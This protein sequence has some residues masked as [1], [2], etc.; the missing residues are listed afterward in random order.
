[1][2]EALMPGNAGDAA[3][4]HA[5]AVLAIAAAAVALAA[6][7]DTRAVVAAATGLATAGITAERVL[8]IVTVA[9]PVLVAVA[10]P[11]ELH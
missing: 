1:M 6:D 4:V 3:V 5:A 10:T 8:D 11:D 7:R 2:A 9:L